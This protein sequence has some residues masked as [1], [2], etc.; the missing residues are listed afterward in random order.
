MSSRHR[1]ETCWSR[2]LAP[3]ALNRGGGTWGPDG[4]VTFA[5]DN[6]LWQVPAEGGAARQVTTL[7]ADE[8]LHAWPAVVNDGKTILFTSVPSSG[9][10]RARVEAVAVDTGTRQV[11]IEGARFPRHTSS[12]HLV[13]YRDGGLHAA[14]FDAN[15]LTVTGAPI[16][17]TAA[18]EQDSTGAPLA[19]IS[20]AGSLV[21]RR[22]G[23][24]SGG[25]CGS[26]VKASSN[27]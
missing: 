2:S 21:Y 3:N 14:P 20:S 7:T 24:A 5:R 25:S 10:Q 11:L 12:G 15:R 22:S 19:E 16:E 27:P 8:S 13:F 26:R 9:V 4:R 17:V 18:V 6:G 23:V 1:C